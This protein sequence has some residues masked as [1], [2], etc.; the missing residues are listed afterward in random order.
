M[1]ILTFDFFTVFVIFYLSFDSR[2]LKELGIPFEDS[3]SDD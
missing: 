2:I 1:Y 3:I